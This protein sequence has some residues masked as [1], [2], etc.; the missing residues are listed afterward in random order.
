MGINL[1]SPLTA[2]K[3]KKL[4]K[5][6]LFGSEVLF[7]VLNIMHHTKDVLLILSVNV[8][9]ELISEYIGNSSFIYLSVVFEFQLDFGR[10]TYLTV[11]FN[12]ATWK[13][14]KNMFLLVLV[15]DKH[16]W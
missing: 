8:K 10:Y 6:S 4:L 16:L 7:H 13:S 1:F 11:S 14:V 9:N 12:C 5:T 3:F 15:Y 2:L